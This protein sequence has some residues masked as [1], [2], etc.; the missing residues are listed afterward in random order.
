ML[1]VITDYNIL[2]LLRILSDKN[3]HTYKALASKLTC[4][5]LCLLK[6][7]HLASKY[8]IKIDLINGLGVF[9]KQPIVWI[10][11]EAVYL[12]LNDQKNSFNLSKFDFLDS[13]NNYLN[14]NKSFYIKHVPTPVIVSELQTN[15]RGTNNRNWF[16]NLGGSLTFSIL[17]RFK[18]K[19][20][21][22]PSLSLVLGISLIRVFKNLSVSDVHIKWP[23]DILVKKKKFAGIL[24]ECGTNVDGSISA[25]IGI[26]IN[27]NLSSILASYVDQPVTDL[28]E[29]SGKHLDRNQILALLLIELRHILLVFE[30]DGFSVF[31]EEWERYHVYQSQ[32]VVLHLPN[33]SS[34]EGIVEGV[35]DDGSLVL[36][37]SSG[38][39]RFNIGV[40]SLR[41]KA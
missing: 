4:T 41:D 23:N 33:S 40:I 21:H 8:G 9:W 3:I 32:S 36:I 37:T 35:Q 24:I 19:I 18:R 10:N 6:S 20:Q 30:T 11:N 39:K 2:K 1:T 15:G 13:T 34:V 14:R 25:I 27:F 29:I 22:I 26:G 7:I 17:W 5:V 31:R 12:Y 28:F 16:S 38:R